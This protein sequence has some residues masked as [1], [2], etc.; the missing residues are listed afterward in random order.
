[1]VVCSK[2]IL[3]EDGRLPELTMVL[4]LDTTDEVDEEDVKSLGSVRS[5]V[6]FKKGKLYFKKCNFSDLNKSPYLHVK[7][8]YMDFSSTSK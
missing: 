1:M 4:E 2:C 8:Q 3:D 7:I 5:P 6:G